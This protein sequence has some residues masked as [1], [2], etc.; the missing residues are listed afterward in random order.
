MGKNSV[1]ISNVG[2]EFK[3][4]ADAFDMKLDEVAYD[5]EHIYLSGTMSGATA[6]PFVEAATGGDT[7]RFAPNDGSLGGDPS[8]EYYY[9]ECESLVQFTT[10]DGGEYI[11]SI[12]PTFTDEMNEIIH[13]VA[14]DEGGEPVIQN[15]KLVSTN[16]EA[17]K[18]W[19]EYLANHAVRFSVELLKVYQAMEPMTGMV[20]GDLSVRLFYGNVESAGATQVLDAD[21]GT[22]RVDANAYLAVTQTTQAKTGTKIALGG[23]HPVTIQEWQPEA[24][25]T[26]DSTETDTYTHE[27]DFT[28]ASYSLK[29]ISFTPTDTKI[30]LH[31]TL[32][33]RWTAAERCYCNLSF[34]ILLYGKAPETWTSYPFEA[35]GPMG[36]ADKTGKKLEYDFELFNSSLSP[37]QWANIKTITILPTTTYYWAMKVSV[38]HGPMQDISLRDGAVYTSTVYDESKPN[39]HSTT[40]QTDPQHDVMTQYALTVNLDDFR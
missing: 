4:Y 8:E 30:T 27:L 38:D 10:A 34:Q 19:D 24:E 1:K 37:S 12:V 36:T 33:D 21:L 2:E 14:T 39:G 17:D 23:I 29:E 9:F 7:Y 11:G 5:G 16:P 28:G 31:V 13:A 40:F 26:K 6:R 25:R 15:G 35:S 22:I 3:A 20:E 32:P 18:L